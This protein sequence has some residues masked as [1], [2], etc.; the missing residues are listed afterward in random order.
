MGEIFPTICAAFLETG[1]SLLAPLCL[2]GRH[3]FLFFPSALISHGVNAEKRS[4][5]SLLDCALVSQ[6]TSAWLWKDP[7]FTHLCL[8]E[9]ARG[10]LLPVKP[11]SCSCSSLLDWPQGM[12]PEAVLPVW[13]DSCRA[14]PK[15][16]L[17]P[18]TLSCSIS[19]SYQTEIDLWIPG[20]WCS[21]DL[22]G[23]PLYAQQGW[24]GRNSISTAAAGTQHLGCTSPQRRLGQACP[25]HLMCLDVLKLQTLNLYRGVQCRY[26]EC[27]LLGK[28]KK[29]P[30]NKARKKLRERISLLFT[31]F[32]SR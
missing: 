5:E 26:S 29:H 7:V 1:K 12:G 24:T 16:P 11:Q 18:P 25:N 19:P 2:P 8:W 22:A 3:W 15:G 4:S 32:F 13:H 21:P 14:L 27:L 23:S 28:K 9:R 17:S 10:S 30:K 6:E 20:H 31:S